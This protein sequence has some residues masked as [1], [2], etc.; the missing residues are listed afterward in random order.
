MAAEHLRPDGL[1][2]GYFC[3][4]CGQPGLNMYGMG[5]DHPGMG[6]ST[7]TPNPELVKTLWE[8]NK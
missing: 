6:N 5:K 3:A 4:R 8:L 2:H 1:Y 7:C